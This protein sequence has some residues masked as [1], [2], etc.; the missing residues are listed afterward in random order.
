MR[1]PSDDVLKVDGA[2][3]ASRVVGGNSNQ[4]ENSRNEISIK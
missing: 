4:K 3:S 2:Y 1:T